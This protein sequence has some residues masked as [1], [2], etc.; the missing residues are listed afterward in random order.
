MKVGILQPG[1]LPWLGFFEQVHRCDIFVFY[2]DVQFDKN[3]WRNRNRIKT[4][5]GPLWLTVPVSHHGHTSQ[6]LLETKI[7]E[8]ERWS[9]KHLNSLKTYY[10]KAPYWDRY[11]EGLTEIYGHEW[12]LLVDLDIAL[13]RYLLQELGIATRTLR[14]SELGIPGD[15]TDRLVSICSALKAHTFY[16]GAAGRDYIETEEFDR[17]GIALEYQDYQH[18]IYP[19][20]YGEFIPYL[21]VIDL[22]FN[23]GEESLTI[24]SGE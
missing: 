12:A 4:P 7:A 18:P 22:M 23:C 9:R 3:S 6:T 13:T 1:Y 10:G 20:L 11:S 5:D 8:K 16:E 17:A 14:S 15:K 24:L 21:S 19:Q 2:D